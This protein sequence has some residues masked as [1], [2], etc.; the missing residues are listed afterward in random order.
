VASVVDGDKLL[1]TA[2]TA[3]K[4]VLQLPAYR[5]AIGMTDPPTRANLYGF[6]LFV[7]RR[8]QIENV[9]ASD[10]ANKHRRIADSFRYS[11]SSAAHLRHF[12]YYQ[13]RKEFQ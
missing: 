8:E 11:S 1:P 7:F 12:K 3:P 9:S 6:E 2:E 13:F 10:A 4:R 5:C